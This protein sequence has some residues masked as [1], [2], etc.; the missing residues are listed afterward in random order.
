[1]SRVGGGLGFGK[2]GLLEDVIVELS[3]K[4]LIGVS[5]VVRREFLFSVEVILEVKN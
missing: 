1:M 5:K 4:R 3:F 2:K